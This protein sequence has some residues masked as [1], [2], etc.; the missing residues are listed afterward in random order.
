M[1]WASRLVRA[2]TRTMTRMAPTP[3]KTMASIFEA[4][5]W[6]RPGPLAMEAR[7]VPHPYS[8][9]TAEAVSMSRR[10]MPKAPVSKLKEH[11]EG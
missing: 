11:E 10:I 3:M 7:R 6:A 4:R 8:D 2:V 1:S 5:N 9:P